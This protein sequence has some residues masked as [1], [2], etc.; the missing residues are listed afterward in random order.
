[1]PTRQEQPFVNVW[2]NTSQLLRS[3]ESKASLLD[4]NK[5]SLVHSVLQWCIGRSCRN[6]DIV[7]MTKSLRVH[8]IPY[9]PC[10]AVRGMNKVYKHRVYGS[11]LQDTETRDFQEFLDN[12]GL[13]E[14]TTI[15]GITSNHIKKLQLADGT[16]IVN[17]NQV[18]D[19]KVNLELL[20]E[21]LPATNPEVCSVVSA[22]QRITTPV[23][24]S[25]LPRGGR[26][27][28]EGVTERPKYPMKKDVENN[29][30]PKEKNEYNE[31]NF[32]MLEK[33]VKAKCILVCGLG[34]DEYN[35]ISGCTS[36]KQLRNTFVNAH[37]GTM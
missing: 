11:E 34:P 31:A 14:L 30:F 3:D 37:L 33:N 28:T 35:R 17:E 7:T 26:E 5:P 22:E 25:C 23:D 20:L 29:V 21:Y 2:S 15:R 4:Y 1:M 9:I 19:D 10:E 18:K 32:K 8:I 24:S 6:R 36:R 16:W 13:C 27:G 12:F